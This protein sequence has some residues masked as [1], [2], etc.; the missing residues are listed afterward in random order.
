MTFSLTYRSSRYELDIEE[1][2]GIGFFSDVYK[3][4]WRNHNGE[5][6]RVAIKILAP[7][8]P[9]SLFEH[10]MAI[11]KPLRHPNVLALIGAS[12]TLR[13]PPYFFVSPYMK[14]GNL[15]D[16]LKKMGPPL[17]TLVSSAPE[18]QYVALRNIDLL[19]Q[20]QPD[21]LS[22]EIRVFFCKYN[23]PPYVKFQKLEIMV[24]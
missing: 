3:G 14:S 10:E 17:V 24:Q 16:Y 22:K 19:L 5:N 20:K 21:I 8:T 9:K 15:V 2:I 23:D 1:K 6:V 4:I 18:V 12:S 7:T 13:N 11:W